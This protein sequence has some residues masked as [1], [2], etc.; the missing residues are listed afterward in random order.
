MPAGRP[1]REHTARTDLTE[2]LT[3]PRKKSKPW[4]PPTPELYSQQQPLSPVQPSV[5]GPPH[6]ARD[7][8]LVLRDGVGW[9]ADS[10]K[11]TKTPLRPEWTAWGHEARAAVRKGD[12]GALEGHAPRPT[13]R[14]LGSRRVWVD[15]I[16]YRDQTTRA[17]L[18][19]T[20]SFHQLLARPPLPGAPPAPKLG[21]GEG[22]PSLPPRPPSKCS[23]SEGGLV[24][25]EPVLRIPSLGGRGVFGE[26]CTQRCPL[27][28]VSTGPA[29]KPERAEPGPGAHA[30]LTRPVQCAPGGWP[31]TPAPQPSHGPSAAS[32]RFP[33]ASPPRSPDPADPTATWRRR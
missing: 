9:A 1:A 14:T 4:G 19:P 17:L 31:R 2:I 28:S 7:R 26:G 16:R 23:Q 11:I 30:P 12:V 6:R 18:V 10:S 22:V 27:R 8:S 20:P 5:P 13:G 32:P 29:L 25:G 24:P 33:A 3:H 21:G 15:P